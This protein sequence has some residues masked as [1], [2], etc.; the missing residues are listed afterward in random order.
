MSIKALGTLAI[1][2]AL[3]AG[4]GGTATK[5][6]DPTAAFLAAVKANMASELPSGMSGNKV[7]SGFLIAG[8]QMC[9]MAAQG[10]TRDEIVAALHPD[11]GAEQITARNVDAAETYLCPEHKGH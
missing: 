4:C 3:I 9:D 10:K 7:D 2:A 6:A 8:H 11:P 5:P 1:A